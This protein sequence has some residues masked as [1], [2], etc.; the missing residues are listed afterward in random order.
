[1][2]KWLLVLGV[3]VRALFRAFDVVT[4]LTF[5]IYM[6]LM[7]QVLG[8]DLAFVLG[9]F[10]LIRGAGHL[11]AL[12]ECAVPHGRLRFLP[13]L[14]GYV[15]TLSTFE[16][17]WDEGFSTLGAPIW[18]LFSSLIAFFLYLTTGNLTC[19]LF[20]MTSLSINLVVLLPIASNFDG[21]IV[22]KS[23]LFSFSRPVGLFF[24]F[25]NIFIL[26]GII[27]LL[28]SKSGPVDVMGLCPMLIDGVKRFSDEYNN[29]QPMASMN[30]AELKILSGLYLGIFLAFLF[31]PKIFN[32][33]AVSSVIQTDLFSA[34]SMGIIGLLFMAVLESNIIFFLNLKRRFLGNI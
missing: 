1:M 26:P 33:S 30:S 15:Q 22:L 2:T 11:W 18:I 25:V 23:I 13:F 10:Y 12:R 19:L 32:I 28:L 7:H 6:V 5:A 17:R 16:R 8:W 3:F 34:V 4:V 31:V 9:F 27:Y 29:D 21:S 20:S 24:M 14:G